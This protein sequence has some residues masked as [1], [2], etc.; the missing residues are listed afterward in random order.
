M[1]IPEHVALVREGSAAVTKF[2]TDN[3]GAKLDLSGADLHGVDLRNCNLSDAN[4]A[5]ADLTGADLRSSGLGGTDLR[6]ATLLN[7][8][9]RGTALHRAKLQECDLR[10]VNLEA[11]GV[12][13]QLVCTSPVSFQNARW[14]KAKL[15]EILGI[16]NLNRDWEIRY[17]IVPKAQ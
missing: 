16:L 3:P 12:G 8:D 17:E 10:G 2:Q 14:D 11:I 15:E 1:A 9:V 13:R 7:A 5:G 6:G 4:L